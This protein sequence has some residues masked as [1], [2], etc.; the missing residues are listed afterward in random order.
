MI[1][2]RGDTSTVNCGMK[3]VCGHVQGHLDRVHGT[4]PGS[5]LLF[6]EIV[7]LVNWD[8]QS[9]VMLGSTARY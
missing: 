5:G 3:C 7:D 2:P 1:L 6:G 9:P 8:E 4:V